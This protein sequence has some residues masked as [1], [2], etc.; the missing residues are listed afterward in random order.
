MG[1]E[2]TLIQLRMT[3]KQLEKLA[4]KAQK[5]QEIERTKVKKAIESKNLE[6]AQ[7]YA[8]NSIRKKNEYLNY[9]RLASRVDA[10]QSKVKSAMA[11]QS[12]A[13]NIGN[14]SK[15]LESAMASLDLEKVSKIMEKF[16]QQFT[17]LDVKAN[18]LED[19]M[20]SATTLSTPQ[21]QVELL[22]K[23]VAE[24]NGLEIIGKMADAPGTSGLS[25]PGERA[26]QRSKA[27]EDALT[28]RLAMLRN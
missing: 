19:T 10:V 11:M 2:D 14:V 15:S 4:Q 27:E 17:D 9:L 25:L 8:E 20:S 24:E 23:Q 16:E 13:K 5:Q 12:V 1:I 7:I 6:G 26:T 18:V 28:S 21:T 3:N 22:I